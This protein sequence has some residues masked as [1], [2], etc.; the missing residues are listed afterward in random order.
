MAS[1]STSPRSALLDAALAGVPDAKL[2]ARLIEAYLD[3]KK[4]HLEARYDLAGLNA[5]KFCEVVLRISQ[6]R[7]LGAS[8]PLGKRIP[9]FADE[10]RAL[11]V[12]PTAAGPESIREIIPRALVFLYTVRN[13][14]GIGHV[15]GDVDAN[16]VD[17]MT[18]TQTAD[19]VVCEL[20]RLF[21]GLSLE[22][23]QD[24]VDTLSTRQLPLIWEVGGKKRVLRTGLSAAEE[25]MLLLYADNQMAVLTEDLCAW[26]EYSNPSVFRKKVLQKL[27]TERL[28]EYDTD[29]ELVHLSPKGVAKVESE[30]L[31]ADA[32]R[33]L[34]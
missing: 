10:C 13:K 28:I 16:R 29:S 2:R 17:T 6:Q 24:I 8:T 22:E 15:G 12:S 4:A 27:H 26:V 21:H 18:M 19:W 9:N 11:V 33:K 14:R 25:V 5:G 23:A 34:T 20:I 32:Y 1:T 31:H 7:V 3:L 30:L